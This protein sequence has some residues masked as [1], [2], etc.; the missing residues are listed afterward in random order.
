MSKCSHDEQGTYAEVA[1]KYVRVKERGR[2]RIS[3]GGYSFVACL[4]RL[5][6]HPASLSRR[7]SG[8]GGGRLSLHRGGREGGAKLSA[9][10]GGSVMTA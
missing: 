9:G 3:R 1:K 4:G 5:T 10:A 7:S 2:L 6:I 8:K